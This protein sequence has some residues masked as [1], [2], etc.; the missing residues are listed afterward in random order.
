MTLKLGLTLD[1][2][3]ALVER[4]NSQ[5]PLSQFRMSYFDIAKAM[6]PIEK[7]PD[8]ALPCYA[9]NPEP[10]CTSD[11]HPGWNGPAAE[12]THPDCIIRTILES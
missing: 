7:M 10:W 1:Q 6:I 12:C 9:T 11:G 2:I 8:G 3:K 4:A 5:R